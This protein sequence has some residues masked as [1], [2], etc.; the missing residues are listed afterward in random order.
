MVFK[1]FTML[2]SRYKTKIKKGTGY[3]VKYLRKE[4]DDPHNRDKSDTLNI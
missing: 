1:P 4:K 2:L 3:A